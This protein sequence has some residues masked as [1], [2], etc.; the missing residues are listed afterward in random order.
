MFF[1]KTICIESNWMLHAMQIIHDLTG[2]LYSAPCPVKQFYS[3][4]SFCVYFLLSFCVFLFGY[5]VGVGGGGGGFCEFVCVCH[6][7]SCE[8]PIINYISAACASAAGV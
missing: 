3:L 7:A 4:L 2:E 8:L 1:E 6:R 5:F